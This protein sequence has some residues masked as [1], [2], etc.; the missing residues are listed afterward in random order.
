MNAKTLDIIDDIQKSGK[1]LQ[2]CVAS[3]CKAE[4]AAGE[5]QRLDVDKQKGS[6]LADL[7]SKKIDIQEYKKK[8]KA[9]R[10]KLPKTKASQELMK[11]TLAKCEELAKKTLQSQIKGL[12]YYCSE[13]N[14][15]EACKKEAA[16][17]KIINKE[18]LTPKDFVAILKI[19]Q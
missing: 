9:I 4:F 18:K 7:V 12:S 1:A 14:D 19:F 5:Q 2:K 10:D 3:R 17:N 6:L 13:K 8:V 11:C 16:A 15:K